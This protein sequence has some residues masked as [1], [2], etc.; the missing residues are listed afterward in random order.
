METNLP[1]LRPK[2]MLHFFLNLFLVIVL[3]VKERYLQIFWKKNIYCEGSCDCLKIKFFAARLR[4]Q[5][6][7]VFR[8][9][10]VKYT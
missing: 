10:K 5:I 4:C 6:R 8:F 9:Q 1:I 3:E 7:R 2:K